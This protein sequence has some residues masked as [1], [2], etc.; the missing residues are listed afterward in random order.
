MSTNKNTCQTDGLLIT[1][2]GSKLVVEVSCV[3]VFF[4]QFDGQQPRTWNLLYDFFQFGG[5]TVILKNRPVLN[6]YAKWNDGREFCPR[7]VSISTIRSIVCPNKY[8]LSYR[9]WYCTYRFIR[10]TDAAT[11]TTTRPKTPTT[12]FAVRI[13]PKIY[14][15][16][17][18]CLELEHYHRY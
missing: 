5:S 8:S 6:A 12:R 1:I 13:C 7:L 11:T 16:I 4:F 10:R 15:G 2:D 18:V 9:Y 14:T 3:G 17:F